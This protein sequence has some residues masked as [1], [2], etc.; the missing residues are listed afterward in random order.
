MLVVTPH[1]HLNLGHTQALLKLFH[2]HQVVRLSMEELSQKP[3]LYPLLNL[4]IRADD[5]GESQSATWR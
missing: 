4:L 1:S 3:N 5:L 2:E